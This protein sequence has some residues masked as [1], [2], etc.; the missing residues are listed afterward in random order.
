MYEEPNNFE[1]PT[2]EDFVPAPPKPPHPFDR[3][4]SWSDGKSAWWIFAFMIVTSIA[5]WKYFSWFRAINFDASA[6]WQSVF[7]EREYWRLISALFA[8]ASF[9]HIGNNSITFLIFAWVLAAY[10]G[11]WAFPIGGI[12]IGVISNAATLYYYGPGTSLLGASGMNYGL[13]AAWLVLYVRHD[14]KRSISQRIMRSV[15]F[16]MM[17]LLP[18]QYDPKVSY[19]AHISG[20]I[21]GLLY[22]T[23]LALLLKPRFPKS[24]KISDYSTNG[25]HLH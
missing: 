21:C 11:K 8:H 19:A 22:G 10:F 5:Q 16:A 25:S 12:L 2:D 17:M 6:S 9:S 18:Q 13:V 20:L 3:W 14:S 24:T 4:P 23:L 7:V 15:G 1:P